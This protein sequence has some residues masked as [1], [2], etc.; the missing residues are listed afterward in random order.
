MSNLRW[1]QEIA[2]YHRILE[3]SDKFDPWSQ[4]ENLELYIVDPQFD[5]QLTRAQR[6]AM[7]SLRNEPP[8]LPCPY[9][10]VRFWRHH[11]RRSLGRGISLVVTH[12]RARVGRNRPDPIGSLA[13]SVDLKVAQEG[14]QIGV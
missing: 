7:R 2:S 10:L 3:I 6:R 14:S 1:A 11:G 12:C 8:S 5:H 4:H 13:E 9:H